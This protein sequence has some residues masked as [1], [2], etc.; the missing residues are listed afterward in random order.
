LADL[1][2]RLSEAAGIFSVTK[3]TLFS[4]ALEQS[5]WP[6]PEDLLVGPTGVAFGNGNLPGA[7]KT[8]QGFS[9]TTLISS[10]SRWRH[11]Y[12]FKAKDVEILLTCRRWTKSGRNWRA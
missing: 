7:A 10:S 12:I 3:N 1:R 4:R 8:I 5:G 9:K 2:R 11:A 6:V